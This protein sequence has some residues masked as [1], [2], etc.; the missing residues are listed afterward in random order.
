MIYETITSRTIEDGIATRYTQTKGLRMTRYIMP[1]GGYGTPDHVYYST[2]DIVAAISE[3]K[4][5]YYPFGKYEDYFIDKSK[6]DRLLEY[7]F[8]T[9]LILVG[10]DDVIAC[11]RPDLVRNVRTS[12]GGRMDRNDP[13]D[14]D[15]LYHYKW[16]DF[17]IVC[18]ARQSCC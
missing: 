1:D 6:V 11:V 12:I 9:P 3:T 18:E 7:I 8:S 5:R 14:Q 10:F 2:G 17:E 4:R 16:S 15:V 13:N